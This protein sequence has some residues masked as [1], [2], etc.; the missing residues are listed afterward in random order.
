MNPAT[1]SDSDSGR[2]KGTLFNS[3]RMHTKL[4][5]QI[6]WLKSSSEQSKTKEER[7]NFMAG[8]A[9]EKCLW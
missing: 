5:N 6:R 8:A 1:S 7:M 2:S 3:A 4:V 9:G